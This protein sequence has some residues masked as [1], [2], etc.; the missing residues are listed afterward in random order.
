MSAYESIMNKKGLDAFQRLVTKWKTLSEGIEARTTGLPIILPDVFLISPSGTG[1]TMILS[2]LAEFLSERGNLLDFYGD[3]KYFEFML[4]YCKPEE[5]FTEI[6]RLMSNVA[7]AAG[8]RNEYRGI[9][10]I[11]VDEWLG[12]FNEKHFISFLEYLADNSD[13]WMVVLS[14]LG[15]R[16]QQVT[17]MER[18]LSAFLR[19]ET[20]I[21]EEPTTAELVY[22]FEN[23]LEKYGF[24]LSDEGRAL[25]TATVDTMKK[26]AYFD[27]YKT[28]KRFCQDVV[29]TVYASGVPQNTVLDARALESFAPDGAYANRSIP[30]LAEFKKIGF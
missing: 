11:E 23:L 13:G 12:H 18:V 27:G 5:P 30:K 17:D 15:G 4:N 19:I 28:T 10:F 22:Y 25:V 21:I 20:V 14:V 6:T 8:F 3:V 1:R 29:Y 2:L 7:V 26:N 24:T 9:L 16:R